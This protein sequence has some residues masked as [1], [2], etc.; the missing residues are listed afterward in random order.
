LHHVAKIRTSPRGPFRPF[1]AVVGLMAEDTTL[2]IILFK[3]NIEVNFVSN[4]WGDYIEIQP[5]PELMKIPYP[6]ADCKTIGDCVY[7]QKLS[8]QFH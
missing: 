8:L 5:S 6:A 3:W 4:L 7:A 1:D 2:I